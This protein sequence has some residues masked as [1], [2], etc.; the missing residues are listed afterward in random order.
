MPYCEILDQLQR[1]FWLEGS[2]VGLWAFDA[3]GIKITYSRGL[4]H[5]KIQILNFHNL[6]HR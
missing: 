5:K 6:T 3:S 1:H 4:P 2:T